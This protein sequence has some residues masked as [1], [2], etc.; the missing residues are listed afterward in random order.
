LW[1]ALKG[2]SF[3]DFESWGRSKPRHAER[4]TAPEG[5]EPTTGDRRK[6]EWVYTFPVLEAK[7]EI[8]VDKRRRPMI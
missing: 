2:Q 6:A 1:Q 5:Q 3:P 7:M 8:P 4:R